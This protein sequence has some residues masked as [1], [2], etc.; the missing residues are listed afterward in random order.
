MH[1]FHWFYCMFT[2]TVR[3]HL[4]FDRH[5]LFNVLLFMIGGPWSPFENYWKLK[6]EFKVYHKRKQLAEEYV[7]FIWYL[8]YSD[9]EFNSIPEL[10]SSRILNINLI[11]RITFFKCYNIYKEFKKIF[12]KSSIKYQ[13]DK[14]KRVNVFLHYINYL[15]EELFLLMIQWDFHKKIVCVKAK[16]KCYCIVWLYIYVSTVHPKKAAAK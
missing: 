3:I 16:K 10:W 4:F 8:V 11:E 14:V 13:Q 9:Q 6:D 15:L 5:L 12:K 1:S 2:C 7:G